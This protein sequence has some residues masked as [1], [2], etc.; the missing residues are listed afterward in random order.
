MLNTAFYK[1]LHYQV[2]QAI[3]SPDHGVRTK[4]D[5]KETDLDDTGIKLEEYKQDEVIPDDGQK[6]RIVIRMKTE[7]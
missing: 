6:K 2:H 3:V 5:L 7:L 1:A 4:F